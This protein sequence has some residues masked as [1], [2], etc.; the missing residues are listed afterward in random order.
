MSAI[1]LATTAQVHMLPTALNVY[2]IQPE[3]QMAS[4]YATHIGSEM[5]VAYTKD[6]AIQNV[7]PAMAQMPAIATIALT[8]L[9][10]IDQ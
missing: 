3:T 10:G 5:T 6:H 2:H 9:H 1:H 8:M 7:A 4:V